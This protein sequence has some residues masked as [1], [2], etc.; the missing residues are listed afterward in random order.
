MAKPIKFVCVDGTT[1]I[2]SKIA[3]S[4]RYCNR[5]ADQ[6]DSQQEFEAWAAQSCCQLL[7]SLARHGFVVRK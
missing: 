2:S 1:T 4:I 3:K 5:Q 7:V 6:W